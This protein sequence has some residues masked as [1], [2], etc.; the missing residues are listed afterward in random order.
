MVHGGST[1][2][3]SA[4]QMSAAYSSFVRSLENS[5]RSAGRLGDRRSLRFR[6]RRATRCHAMESLCEVRNCRSTRW[7]CVR[8]QESGNGVSVVIPE[9][10]GW[11]VQPM[12]VA[13][14]GEGRGAKHEVAPLTR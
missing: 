13:Y 8:A 9:Q 5:R 11:V 6:D 3:G 1:E 7:R 2:H 14:D 4:P 12:L 10:D